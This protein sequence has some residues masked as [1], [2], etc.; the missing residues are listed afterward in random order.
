MCY[1][2]TIG[3]SM[4]ACS[5]MILYYVLNLHVFAMH[6]IT[7]LTLCRDLIPKHSMFFPPIIFPQELILIKC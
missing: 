3:G 1:S 6:R 7:N 2:D 4:S 5:L